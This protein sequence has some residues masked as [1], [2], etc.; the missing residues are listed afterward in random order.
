M[1][2][3]TAVIAV[4]NPRPQ[5]GLMHLG[6]PLQL[7]GNGR[8]RILH[9]RGVALRR[10]LENVRGFHRIQPGLPQIIH[11]RAA[12]NGRR[13]QPRKAIQNLVPLLHFVNAGQQ[14][15]GLQ[16]IHARHR[17][18]GQ[19]Q[20]PRQ[21]RP[22]THRSNHILLVRVHFLGRPAQPALRPQLVRLAGMPN[23]HRPEMR[24][25]RV[26]IAHPMQN[27]Q[28]ALLIQVLQR[29]HRRMQP[30]R[31]VQLQDFLLRHPHRRP[32]VPIARVGVRN[33]RVQVI[34]PPGQ[35]QNN[36]HRVFL[37]SSHR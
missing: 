20:R 16:V 5:T 32:V 23:V 26:G 24:P 15:K 13:I 37:G 14:P 18:G 25:G 29:P 11:H 33:D 1:A 28:L 4:E 31:I 7:A 21:A 34:V 22:E 10:H 36:Q 8:I 6:N 3:K 35:L 12:A 27:R 19:C 9:I 2:V 30:H 17:H